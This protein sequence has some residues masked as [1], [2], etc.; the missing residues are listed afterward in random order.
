MSRSIY[1]A[2]ARSL[3]PPF[4]SLLMLR[5]DFQMISVPKTKVSRRICPEMFFIKKKSRFLMKL[6]ALITC[7][8]SNASIYGEQLELLSHYP[9]IWDTNSSLCMHLCSIRHILDDCSR[10]NM[11]CIN[12]KGIHGGQ[13]TYG[14]FLYQY[15]ISIWTP[16]LCWLIFFCFHSGVS[17]L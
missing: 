12:R 8:Q 4:I 1:C 15:T 14:S 9:E 17:L 2:N 3:L 16:R 10:P 6:M 7:I 5:R 11:I 13:C